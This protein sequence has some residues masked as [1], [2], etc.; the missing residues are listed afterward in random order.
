MSTSWSAPTLSAGRH[1]VPV[2]RSAVHRKSRPDS[3]AGSAWV[4]PWP[5]LDGIRALA[6]SAVVIYH[7]GASWLPGGFLGVDVF[8]VL[9]GFLITSLLLDEWRRTGWISVGRFYLRRARRLLPALY[10]MLLTV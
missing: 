6:V 8:F 3:P 7:L 10:L 9:S 5:A 4:G 1:R 2:P